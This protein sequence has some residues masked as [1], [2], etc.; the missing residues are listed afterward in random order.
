MTCFGLNNK[1]VIESYRNIRRSDIVVERMG[2]NDSE[3]TSLRWQVENLTIQLA[4]LQRSKEVE[5]SEKTELITKRCRKREKENKENKLLRGSVYRLKM[6]L[7]KK[8]INEDKLRRERDAAQGELSVQYEK[9]NYLNEKCSLMEEAAAHTPNAVFRA[10][11]K[12]L[13][14]KYHPD[15]SAE[16]DTSFSGSEITMDLVGLL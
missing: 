15:K 10:N 9:L 12:A 6:V 2:T 7:E 8:I 1:G 14:R 3:V 13:C 11:V 4:R 16:I 5:L